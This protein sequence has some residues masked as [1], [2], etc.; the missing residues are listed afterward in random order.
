MR[1]LGCLLALVLLSACA[2]TPPAAPGSPSADHTPSPQQ[3]R[4]RTIAPA[5]SGTPVD[6]PA[7]RLAAI[8]SDLR[9]RG[10]TGDV[11]VIS[12]ENVR[13]TDGS[14]G[15][16][17]PGVQYTQALVDG[18]RVVVEVGGRRFDYRFGADDA[19]QLC[20]RRPRAVR[21]K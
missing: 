3:T 6:L 11:V 14:L 18:M 7:S 4:Y 19:P 16:P 21:T 13:F 12:A 8:T 17:Q 9:G 15:C 20:E 2:M 10:V 5:P 1:R